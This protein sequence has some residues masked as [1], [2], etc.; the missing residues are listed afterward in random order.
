MFWPPPASVVALRLR[1]PGRR[2]PA[3]PARGRSWRRTRPA[4]AWAAGSPRRGRSARRPRRALVGV[5][6]LDDGEDVRV[7]AVAA[8]ARSRTCPAAGLLGSACACSSWPSEMLSVTSAQSIGRRRSAVLGVGDGDR[9]RDRVAEVGDL[10]SS[11]ISIVTSGR[12]LPTV[13][14][15]LSTPVAPAVGH[16]SAWRCSCRPVYVCV[17]FGSVESVVP[18]P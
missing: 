6:R 1:R 15:T 16:A 9:V 18:S 12:V 4:C 7:G 17:G 13:I 5:G 14:G 3:R 10:P 8:R 2:R 11:G